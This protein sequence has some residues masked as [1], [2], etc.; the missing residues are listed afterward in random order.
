[1]H[2]EKG[3]TRAFWITFK[4]AAD[5]KPG[6][7]ACELRLKAGDKILRT[8]PIALK[9]RSFSLPAK[10]NLQ[11][12]YDVWLTDQWVTTTQNQDQIGKRPSRN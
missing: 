10:N 4:T 5:A 2:L 1:M 3:K 8:I 12:I 7:Y 11:V 6:N 9:I